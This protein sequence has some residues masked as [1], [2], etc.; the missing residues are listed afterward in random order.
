MSQEIT[1][2]A[3]GSSERTSLVYSH[4]YKVP[5]MGAVELSCG[6]GP[7]G[8]DIIAAICAD[9]LITSYRCDAILETGCHFGDT[10]EYLARMY[11]SLAI[12]ACDL[13]PDKAAIA[14]HRLK[15]FSNV[16]IFHDDSPAFLGR[17]IDTYTLPFIYLD[18]HWEATWPLKA[19][20]SLIRRAI[21]CIDDFDVRHPRFAFDSYGGVPCGL[22]ILPADWRPFCFRLN[23]GA[24]VGGLPCLQIGRRG[25]KCYAAVGVTAAHLTS[26]DLFQ[27]IEGA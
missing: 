4:F 13:S 23:P 19:E 14:T 17:L 10:T 18:A 5:R 20:L 6:G 3:A 9:H 7:F 2:A 15:R 27:P 11:P 26:S 1:P 21:L 22:N 8:F 24:N 25:G 12:S 16:T